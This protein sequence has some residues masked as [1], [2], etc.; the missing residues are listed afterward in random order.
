MRILDDTCRALHAVDSDTADTK[1]IEKLSQAGLG[2]NKYL[3]LRPSTSNY[4]AGFT[5][6]H[7]AGVVHYDVTE[8]A[9]KNMDNL[10]GSLVDCMK[11]S[12]SPFMRFLWPP[13][14]DLIRQAPATSSTKIR[15]SA[16]ALVSALRR[17]ETHYVRCIKSNDDKLPMTMDH[18]RCKHQVQYQ[19]LKENVRVKK[20]GYSYRAPYDSF[21]HEFAILASRHEQGQLAGGRA[22]AQQLTQFIS[23]KWADI[24]PGSEWAFGT[25]LIFV[26]SPETIFALQELIEE[27]KDPKGYAEK[28][29]AHEQAEQQALKQEAKVKKGKVKGEGGGCAVC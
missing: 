27:A 18:E 23:R 19:G 1:F 15:N 11:Q 16:S 25:S 7:Y 14:E 28:V 17:C 5:I 20:A 24:C 10:Y 2:G 12:E 29:R 9:F 13:D 22:G 4:A 3:R 21:L 26:H 8:M 6:T